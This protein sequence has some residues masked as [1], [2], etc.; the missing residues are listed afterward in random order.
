V[1][2]TSK[3]R[4]LITPLSIREAARHG[5]ERG[6]PMPHVVRA[7]CCPKGQINERGSRSDLCQ[8]SGVGLPRRRSEFTGRLMMKDG[9]P[10][11]DGGNRWAV[12][13]VDVRSTTDRSAATGQDSVFDRMR[14]NFKA[15]APADRQRA[16]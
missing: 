2:F 13:L 1:V 14:S 7:L 6:V 16:V 10:R 5:T 12:E 15:Q 11:P 9:G 3:W 8:S 4:V